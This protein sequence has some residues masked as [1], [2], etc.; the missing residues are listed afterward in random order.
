M[1]FFSKIGKGISN[2]VKGVTKVVGNVV[3]TVAPV[4]AIIPGVGGIVSAVAGIVGEVLSPTKQAAI[5][6][7]VG[8]QGVV[9]VDKIENTILASNPNIDA[10]TLQAATS[11]MTQQA[12]NANPTAK[13]DDSNSLTNVPFM[14]K[15]IQWVKSNFLI[16]G[17]GVVGLFLIFKNKGGRRRRW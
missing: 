6:E 3:K 5:E 15:A 4:A 8:E 1:G 2:A 9:K 11:A 13:I 14:T 12:L 7:A 16:V 17:A 10:G